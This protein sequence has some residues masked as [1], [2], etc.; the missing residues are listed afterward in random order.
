MNE[1]KQIKH[2]VDFFCN[3]IRDAQIGLDEVRNRCKHPNTFE[4]NYEWRVGATL[5]AEICAD[6]GKLIKYL[7]ATGITV[8]GAPAKY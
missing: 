6:C 2:Q 3:A 4:G 8:I 1:Q 7:S 5:E